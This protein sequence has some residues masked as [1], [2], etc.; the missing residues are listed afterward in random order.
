MSEISFTAEEKGVLQRIGDLTIKLDEVTEII[1]PNVRV[2][3]FLCSCSDCESLCPCVMIIQ[4]ELKVKEVSR[5]HP[6]SSNARSSISMEEEN[7]GEKDKEKDVGLPPKDTGC[8]KRMQELMRQFGTIL[9]QV[10]C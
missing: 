3:C 2:S 8:R 5:F 1:S 7:G 4:L 10:R 6:S 9:R